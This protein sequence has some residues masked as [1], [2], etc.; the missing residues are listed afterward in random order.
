[1]FFSERFQVSSELIKGYGAVDIS[2]VCDIPLFIDPMLIF[3]S[4]KEVYKNLHESIVRYFHFLYTKATQG[5]TAKEIN[6]WFNFSEVP[7]NWLGYSLVGNK[8]LA[9]GEKYA[10]F[11]YKNIAFAI[12]THG[13]S[14]S[15]HIEKVMLLYDGSGKDKIS[16]LTVNL[17]KGFLCEY[18]ETFSLRYIN[19]EFLGKFPVDKAYFNYRTE[20]FV[21]KEYVLPY[22]YDERGRKE[23]V[24]LTP[25]D[26]LR[27]DEPS[28]NR[29]DFYDSYERIRIAIENDTL[30]A[31]VNNYIGLAVKQYEENQRRNRRASREKSIKK[32][33][34]AAFRE[35]A[36][37]YP[38]LYDYYIKLRETDIDE[39]RSTCLSELNTQLE[40]LFV[41]S[42][43]IISLF[44]N[45]DYQVNEKLTAR[46]EAKERLRYFKHIIEDCDGYKNLY[47]K[48]KQI[49]KENDLQRLFRFVWYGTNYKVDA[50]PN[51][52]RGQAD[53]I[54]SMGQKDQS[55]V[56]FKL[57]SNSTL[58]HV[59]TQVK[60]Y[61]AA[62]CADG[63]LIA[64]FYFSESEYLYSEQIVKAAGYESMIGESIYLIDCRNDNKPSASIA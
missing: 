57:A 3:N 55:I 38:E 7:N 49:A 22:V 54:V 2:L 48:G 15:Q 9:L 17:I 63:S 29:K 35:L 50:E 6:A 46:E 60:I 42:Q 43:K 8:G 1:M 27:E 16:D 31:Y 5:L 62:N 36:R 47:V 19:A 21:S 12:N 11:L 25:Y 13:I 53:F 44:E 59:F 30:R 20:S 41:A 51:N 18:T 40:K 61:E 58:A 56:E 37:E 10:K 64:I 26:I 52:G 33:E 23:Y 34:K 14:Q 45:Q 39:I 24:L 28:I 4:E 32:I